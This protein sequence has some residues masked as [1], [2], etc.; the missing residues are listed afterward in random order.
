MDEAG[1]VDWCIEVYAEPGEPPDEEDPTVTDTYPHDDDYPSGVPP[2]ENVAGCHWRD[3]D[4][5]DNSGIDVGVSSFD[6]YDANMDPVIGAATIDDTDEYDVVVDFQADDLWEDGAM[7]TV[8][9]T[10][11]DNAGNSASDEWTFTTGYTNIVEKSFGA[12]KVDFAQ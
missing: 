11:Y 9:T 6:V 7:Y 1:G 4:P 12:I 10:A 3:G 8:E 5:E 2:E